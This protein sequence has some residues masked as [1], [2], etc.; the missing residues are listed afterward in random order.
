L[1]ASLVP[2]FAGEVYVPFASNKL[3]SGS[4][5]QTRVWVTNSSTAARS[6]DVRFIEEDTDGTKPGTKTTLNVP[7]GTTM[8]VTNVAPSGKSGMLEISGAP[9]ITVTS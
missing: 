1:F 9:Q 3:I 5:Y 2:A 6:C 8:V 7:A 4:L